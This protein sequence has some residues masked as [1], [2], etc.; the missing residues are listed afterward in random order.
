MKGYLDKI[1][2]NIWFNRVFQILGFV[3]IWL[4]LGNYASHR[5]S[6]DEFTYKSEVFADKAGYFVYLPATFIYDFDASKFPKDVDK[7]TGEGFKLDLKNNKIRTKYTCGIAIL[8]SPFFL[9]NHLYQK[10]S[11]KPTSGFNKSYS[12]SLNY[13]SVFYLLIG[14]IFLYSYLKNFYKK[15]LI[16][17]TL[18]ILFL[19]SHIF[20][21][22]LVDTFMTHVYSFSLF[23]IFLWTINKYFSGGKYK[24]FIL[25]TV[26]AALITLIRPI[27]IVFLV[28]IIFLNADS[29]NE[30]KVRFIS[31]FTIKN[32]AVCIIVFLIV[33]MP[34][35]LYFKYVSGKFLY[36][37]Y[38][39]ESFS[40]L[41][42]PKIIEVLFSTHNGLLLYTPIFVF[43][44]AGS[45]ILI[46]KKKLNGYLTLFSFL[47]MVYISASWWAWA[48]GCSFSSRPMVD[49]LPVLSI[50]FIAFIQWIIDFKSWLV[51]F[52]AVIIIG[53]MAYWNVKF[54]ANYS[55]CFMGSEWD[56]REFNAMLKAGDVF[57]FNTKAYS[58]VFD[59]LIPVKLL[60]QNGDQLF[61]DDNGNLLLG[62]TT[63]QK[64]AEFNLI[65]T[66]NEEFALMASNGN[67]ITS[68]KNGLCL[69]NRKEIGSWER[70]RQY[71]LNNGYFAFV[72]SF[73]NFLGM[74]S[75]NQV[76]GNLSSHDNAIKLKF[77]YLQK[78]K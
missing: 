64:T 26:L 75:N 48:W 14:F 17:L 3:F 50:S 39:N 53:F 40:N 15:K 5:N 57:P 51:K 16:I 28:P 70:F 72:N 12:K 59:K 19:T 68:E 2:K 44:V 56:W 78:D 10:L 32:I 52:L 35:F 20:Y 31:L 8:A 71:K 66:G 55:R 46:V 36:Y 13:A 77:E 63:I 47:L 60:T 23:A 6:S 38:E 61:I 73:G 62:T 69:A 37:S 67:Y 22:S 11:G 74:D 45:I 34:Q 30:I 18:G 25:L 58:S 43:V 41:L 21:Y 65:K 24:Y 76:I 27:N 9:T 29:W 54:S 49:I 7:K 42:T 4:Y 1:S 33:F